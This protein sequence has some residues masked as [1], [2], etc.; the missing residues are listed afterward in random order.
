MEHRFDH[1]N[2]DAYRLALEVAKACGGLRIAPGRAHLRE[3]LVR[4]ADSVVLN[5]AEGRVRS[6]DA[7]PPLPRSPTPGRSSQPPPAQREGPP[8]TAATP[9]PR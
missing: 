2:L 3:R 6:G 1:E 4:A 5:L 7:A 9:L 8:R